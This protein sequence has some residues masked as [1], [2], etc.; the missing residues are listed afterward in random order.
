MATNKTT[1]QFS[2]SV[3][4]WNRIQFQNKRIKSFWGGLKM[5]KQVYIKYAIKQGTS[6]Y[7]TN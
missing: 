4:L 1:K 5:T 3:A 6:I 7:P 2:S